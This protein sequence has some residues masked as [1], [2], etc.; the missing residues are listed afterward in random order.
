MIGTT[1]TVQAVAGQGVSMEDVPDPLVPERVQRRSQTGR[2]TSQT[3]VGRV[4]DTALGGRGAAAPGSELRHFVITC[5]GEG[6][7]EMSGA[8]EVSCTRWG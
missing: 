6:L 5:R 3:R 8:V 1:M 4:R 7:A 2:R